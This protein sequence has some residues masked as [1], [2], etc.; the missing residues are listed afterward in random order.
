MIFR[1]IKPQTR[2][3]PIVFIT[4]AGPSHLEVTSEHGW[5]KRKTNRTAVEL[6]LHD[7]DGRAIYSLVKPKQLASCLGYDRWEVI[8]YHNRIVRL[9]FDDAISIYPFST[10]GP[11]PQA[12]LPFFDAIRDL[13]VNPASMST[14]TRSTWLRSLPEPVWIKEW[15]NDHAGRQAFH[16]GRKEAKQPT[17]AAYS[18]ARYL[19]LSAAYLQAMRAPIPTHLRRVSNS[20]PRNGV[21]SASMHLPEQTWGPIPFRILRG[22]RGSEFC[23]FGY[24]DGQ[25]CWP[26]EEFDLAVTAGA[27]R[28]TVAGAWE[29]YQLKPIFENWLPWAFDLRT[30]PGKAGLAA[31]LLTTRLWSMFAMNPEGHKR[32]VV[33]FGDAKGRDRHV[34]E[35]RGNGQTMGQA[36][37]VAAIIASRVRVRLYRELLGAGT[38]AVYCDTDGGIVPATTSVGGWRETR[39]MDRVEIKGCQAFRWACPECGQDRGHPAWHYSVAGVPSDSGLCQALFQYAMPGQFWDLGPYSLTLPAGDLDDVKEQAEKVATLPAPLEDES[40]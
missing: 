28:I 6:L 1:P 24:G 20:Q 5:T 27:G 17:P 30:L 8:K 39:R 14:M 33:T 18:G 34:V 38:G 10:L 32:Q 16:G 4:D 25:G 23:C 40:L 11:D 21:V 35:S 36:T 19:D 2:S 31:K 12:L 26:R 37:F 29:G 13:G 9:R 7:Q 3:R 22:K 15:G